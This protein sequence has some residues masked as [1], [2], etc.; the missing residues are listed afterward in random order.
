MT[1]QELV[2]HVVPLNDKA[3]A[4]Y[5]RLLADRGS[6]S[7]IVPAYRALSAKGDLTFP[8]LMLRSLFDKLFDAGRGRE[9]KM[10]WESVRKP[11]GRCCQTTLDASAVGPGDQRLLLDSFGLDWVARP[12]E[13]VS[14]HREREASGAYFLEIDFEQP[15]NLYYRHLTRDF[16]VMPREPYLLEAEVRSERVT[17]SEGVRLAVSS[18]RRFL[19]ASP[20]SKRTAP[21]RKVQLYFTPRPG[22]HVLRLAVLRNHSE[23]LD[24]LVSGKFRLRNVRLVALSGDDLKSQPIAPAESAASRQR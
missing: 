7:E 23:R 19:T 4:E 20:P 10:L 13:G 6:W 3:A 12:V 21:W 11:A 14:V 18:H 9:I 22:E 16:A 24:S 5:L 2:N 8:P 15:Q 1:T 17:G